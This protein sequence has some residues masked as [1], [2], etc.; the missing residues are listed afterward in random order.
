[1]RLACWLAAGQGLRERYLRVFEWQADHGLIFFRLGALFPDVR[2]LLCGFDS[3]TFDM[4]APVCCNFEAISVT[5]LTWPQFAIFASCSSTCTRHN[6]GVFYVFVMIVV[7]LGPYYKIPWAWHQWPR[8][9]PS[10]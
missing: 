4:R 10:S 2:Q 7:A 6:L 1:M 8:V 9:K 5:G 3:L